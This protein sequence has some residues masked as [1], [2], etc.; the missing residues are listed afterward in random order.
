M[1]SFVTLPTRSILTTFP[2]A[3]ETITLGSVGILR[4]GF[5]K[6]NARNAERK[7]NKIPAKYNPDTA[8]TPAD[9]SSGTINL[10]ASL[11]I[12]VWLKERAAVRAGFWRQTPDKFGVCP[13]NATRY[14]DD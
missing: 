13:Q 7:G 2:S 10:N 4:A 8:A 5:R 11:W 3:G 9:I 6:K 14:V 12:M 1:L